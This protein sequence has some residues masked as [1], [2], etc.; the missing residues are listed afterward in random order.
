M[1]RWL[2][3]KK[4]TEYDDVV[5]SSRIRLARNLTKFKFPNSLN[6]EEAK[7][8][9]DIF[10]K[11]VNNIDNENKFTV[12]SLKEIDS[13]DRRVLMEE[14]LISPELI[15][16]KDISYYIINE[17]NFLNLMINEEDHL[18]L[19]VLLPGF[20]LYKAFEIAKDTDN[21]LE[22][23]IN[24]AFDKDFGYLTSCP[25]N[26]GTGMRASVMLHLPAL[27]LGNYLQ[28]I[29]DSLTKLGLTIRGVYGEGSDALGDMFQISNQRTLG[30]SEIEVIDKLENIAIKIIE[31]ERKTRRD[32]LSQKT[33]YLKDKV[34]RALG[35]LKY[36]RIISDREALKNLSFLRMGIDL[37]L[38]RGLNYNQITNLMLSVQKYNILK[39]KY[40]LKSFE[41]ENVLRAD[42]IR[43]FFEQEDLINE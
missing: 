4:D 14:H 13:I 24:F 21:K 15:K 37:G 32:L 3:L 34:Y 9:S 8:V 20:E 30:F 10:I 7:E 16:N 26:T 38:Y 25:T 36:A 43:N 29:I 18:R 12:I 6:N 28:G 33:N 17:K 41:E 39:Y 1:V 11:T 40:S 2:E 5:I 42:Y 19:Q 27:K 35:I 23:N 22:E 31:K